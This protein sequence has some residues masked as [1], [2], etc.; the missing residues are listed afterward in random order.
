[1]E[2]ICLLFVSIAINLRSLLL[3]MVMVVVLCR[4][5]FIFK[6]MNRIVYIYVKV[7]SNPSRP[8]CHYIS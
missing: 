7:K 8:K 1:M 2:Y 3:W 5:G 4:Y 6:F